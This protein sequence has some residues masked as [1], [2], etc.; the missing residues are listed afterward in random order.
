MLSQTLRHL[1]IRTIVYEKGPE[2]VQFT[3]GP[4]VVRQTT[5]PGTP[6]MARTPLQD[7]DL[8]GGESD[9]LPS[10]YS[11]VLRNIDRF[12]EKRG[13]KYSKSYD[14]AEIRKIAHSLGIATTKKTK[15]ALVQE[16]LKN[17]KDFAGT[18]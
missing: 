2:E 10:T 15:K 6:G 14:S 1:D 9:I 5:I 3:M 16:I 8:F 11:E 17:A 7:D 18:S 12:N 13:G 4:P